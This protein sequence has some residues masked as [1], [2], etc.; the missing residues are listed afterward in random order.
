MNG[1]VASL[2]KRTDA[3]EVGHYRPIC[4]FPVLYRIW[5]TLRARPVTAKI[6]AIAASGQLGNMPRKHAAMV[7]YRIQESVQ[8]AQA[9]HEPLC[10]YVADVVKAFNC[11]PRAPVYEAAIRLG[12]SGRIL[13]GWLSAVTLMK[14]RFVVRHACGP[15]H[16]SST[17][18]P[19]GCSLSC[20]AMALVDLCSIRVCRLHGQYLT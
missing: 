8:T 16:T 6:A 13:K 10:G 14:R 12:I 1:S 7:W 4:V 18:F 15:P 20:V 3:Q 17:G 2:E 19:E 9:E 11:L 5:S